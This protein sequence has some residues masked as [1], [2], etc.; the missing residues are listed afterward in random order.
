MLKA[1]AKTAEKATVKLI[2]ATV[3]GRYVQVPKG[4]TILDACKVATVRVPTLCY[5]PRYK[6]EAVCR[7]CLVEAKNKLVP[8]CYTPIEDG[9]YPCR[10][11]GVSALSFQTNEN[12]LTI[13]VNNPQAWQLTPTPIS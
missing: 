11:R 4:S 2:R 12:S 9:E 6:A 3:N 8:A 1:A 13:R 5:H 10:K 7:M